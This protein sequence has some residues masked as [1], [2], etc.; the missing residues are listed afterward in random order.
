MN[1]DWSKAFSFKTYKNGQFQLG[2]VNILGYRDIRITGNDLLDKFPPNVLV[3]LV[4]A[5]SR[6]ALR[7]IYFGKV[8]Y[9]LSAIIRAQGTM[10]FW[11]TDAVTEINQNR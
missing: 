4:G 1:I 2:D 10:N 6:S 5:G 9:G 11:F 3:K 8:T 7:I